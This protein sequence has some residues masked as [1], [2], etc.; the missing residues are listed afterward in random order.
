MAEIILDG[1]IYI[2]GW[3]LLIFLGIILFIIG[4]YFGLEILII[5][6]VF[7]TITGVLGVYFKRKYGEIEYMKIYVWLL[8]IIYGILLIIIS[9]EYPDILMF[10]QVDSLLFLIFGII[11]MLGGGIG[12]YF[13]TTKDLRRGEEEKSLE[14]VTPEADL[15]QKENEKISIYLKTLPYFCES[16]K[17]FTYIFRNYCGNCGSR[18]SLREATKE[19]YVKYYTE[20]STIEKDQEAETKLGIKPPSPVEVKV[21]ISEKKEEKPI[22]EV[23]VLKAEEVQSK[24]SLSNTEEKPKVIPPLCE[25]CGNEVNKKQEFC[26]TCGMKISKKL[27]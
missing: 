26:P 3:Y 20:I 8:L 11:M 9:S 21:G 15:I 23:P 2:F 13:R 27:V 7:F 19:D 18:D 22:I 14:T 24:P 6:G 12:I 17:K 5:L 1:I 25:F 16:C 10:F 4:I